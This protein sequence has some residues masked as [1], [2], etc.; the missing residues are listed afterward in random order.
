MPT[1]VNNKSC[2][3]PSSHFILIFN[4][5]NQ[6]LAHHLT[7]EDRKRIVISIPGDLDRH[8]NPLA[9]SGD[10]SRAFL[11]LAVQRVTMLRQTP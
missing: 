11:A 6:T 3:Q 4:R 8:L 1:L 2:L 10:S 7:Q 9:L 5:S